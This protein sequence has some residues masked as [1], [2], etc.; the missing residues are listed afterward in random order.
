MCLTVA[1]MLRMRPEQLSN[2][3]IEPQSREARQ[4]RKAL[5]GLFTAKQLLYCRSF[6]SDLYVKTNYGIKKTFPIS[7]LSENS[8]EKTLCVTVSVRYRYPVFKK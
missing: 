2:C 5:A 4:L 8:A 7:N 3:R 1:E 6:V